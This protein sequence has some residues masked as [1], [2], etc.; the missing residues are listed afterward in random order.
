MKSFIFV[1]SLLLFL[2]PFVPL[3]DY[4]INYE[5]I[6]KELCENKENLVLQCNGKC[7]LMKEMAKTAEE[8][9]PISTDKNNLL[10]EIMPLQ[11]NIVE[12]FSFHFFESDY[13]QIRTPYSNLYTYI[14]GKGI[15]HPPSKFIF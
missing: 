14:L 15:F 8:E 11:L 9:S 6:A 4:A 12:V 2:K 1:I 3:L 5:Y 7:H 10:K 13:T